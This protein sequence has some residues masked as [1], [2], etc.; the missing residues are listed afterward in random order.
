MSSRASASSWTFDAAVWLH[1]GGSWHFVSLPEEAADEIEE[2]YGRHAGGFGSVRVEVTIGSARWKTSLFPDA[3]R[4]TY[5]LPLKQAVRRAE[6]LAA[7]SPATVHLQ[8]L[9]EPGPTDASI[10]GVS[11]GDKGA[12]NPRR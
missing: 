8:V 1:S 2:R 12:G 10:A 11:N 3:K 9:V 6:G 7:G 4:A 5:V